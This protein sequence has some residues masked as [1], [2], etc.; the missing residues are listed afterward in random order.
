MAQSFAT[1]STV[2]SYWPNWVSSE[3][4]WCEGRT[5]GRWQAVGCDGT[6]LCAQFVPHRAP[7]RSTSAAPTNS[8][9]QMPN[10]SRNTICMVPQWR[11]IGSLF[12]FSGALGGM[13]SNGICRTEWRRLGGTPTRSSLPTSLLYSRGVSAPR[14]LGGSVNPSCTSGVLRAG[15]GS[16]TFGNSSWHGC[17]RP[18]MLCWKAGPFA[19]TDA[20]GRGS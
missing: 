10:S 2:N 20:Y 11:L 6:R 15:R 12:A 8:S 4:M 5:P 9:Q 17:R 7:N 19:G 1:P 16:P 18:K 14:M 3:R 13:R